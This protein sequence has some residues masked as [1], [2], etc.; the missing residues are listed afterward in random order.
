M[1][2][3]TNVKLPI[4]TKIFIASGDFMQK[5]WWAVL[6]MVLAAIGGAIYYF[7]TEDGKKEFDVLKL[8]I[9]IVS[10]VF[11]YVYLAR[12]SEN[13][14]TLVRSGLPIVSALQ[15]SGKVIGNSVYEADIIEAAEKVKTGG[16]ISEVLEEQ[17][18]FPANDG[19][20]DKSRGR[21]GKT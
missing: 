17:A 4:T 1:L 2:E 13:L 20:D 9:P 18:E 14:S 16:T 19:S 7:R 10:R 5:W 21:N 6:I 3:E 12:F 15:I 11:Q 8:K